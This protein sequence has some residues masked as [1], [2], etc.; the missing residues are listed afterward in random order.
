MRLTQRFARLSQRFAEDEVAAALGA[1]LEGARPGFG[2]AVAPIEVY[3]PQ[4]A[5]MG[6]EQQTRAAE[7]EGVG[8]G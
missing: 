2:E 7:G 5:G 4:I 8:D 6:S 1:D 3:G